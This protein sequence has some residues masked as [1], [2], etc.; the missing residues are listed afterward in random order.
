MYECSSSQQVG[1]VDIIIVSS[2]T[3]CL[4]RDCVLFLGFSQLRLYKFVQYG[5]LQWNW[6]KTSLCSSNNHLCPRIKRQKQISIEM[7]RED[8]EKLGPSHGKEKSITQ[9]WK[10]RTTVRLFFTTSSSKKSTAASSS[11][12]S[13]KGVLRNWISSWICWNPLR[14]KVWRRTNSCKLLRHNFTIVVTTDSCSLSAKMISW[15]ENN[16]LYFILE[17]PMCFYLNH[18]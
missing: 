15:L 11:T 4:R 7:H 8:W 12:I 1:K 2:S 13:L 16:C 9:I 10:I 17:S 5:R 18:Q 3:K 14:L 6:I